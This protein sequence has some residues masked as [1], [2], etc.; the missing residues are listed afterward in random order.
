[1]QWW[2]DEV[3]LDVHVLPSLANIRNRVEDG[4]GAVM[5]IGCHSIHLSRLLFVVPGGGQATFTGSTRAEPDQRVHVVGSRGRIDIEILFNIPPERAT[6]IHVTAGG[7]PPPAPATETRTFTPTD[8]YTL[9]AEVFAQTIL[10]G[11]APPT[12]LDDALANL[13]VIEAFLAAG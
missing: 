7:D 8:A 10:D 9:Q 5:D 13:R 1:M 11:V 2:W 12:F 6:R 4:G 3:G